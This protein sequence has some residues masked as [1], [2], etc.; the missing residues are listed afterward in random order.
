MI[1][2]I[3]PVILFFTAIIGRIGSWFIVAYLSGA[4]RSLVISLALFTAISTLV[5]NLLTGANAYLLQAIQGMSPISQMMLSPLASM[6]PPSLGL[7]ASIIVSV[8]FMGIVYNLTKEIAKMKARAAER[9]AGF[10]KA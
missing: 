10:F 9:A 5:Y 6:M 8:W 2:L 1:A 3:Q 4:L 7:C